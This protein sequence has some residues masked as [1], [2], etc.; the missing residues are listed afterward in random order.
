M[1]TFDYGYWEV[2]IEKHGRIKLPTALLKSLSEDDRK[3]FVVT[4]GFGKH[5]M[6]WTIKSY[7]AQMDYLNS[8]DRNIIAVKRYRNAFLTR[9]TFVE[10]DK[11][12]RIVIPKPFMEQYGIENEVV[13]LLDNGKIEMW[14][15]EEYHKEF[16][17]SPE[18]LD[19]LNEAIHL[20]Q[21]N[22]ARKEDENELP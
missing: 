1:G 19:S 11:Q 6:L 20:G 12:D 8:L 16:D 22:P 4:P 3:G 21:I 5:V 2:A 18:E 10:C 14:N 7:K 13:L 15:S 9:N 17:M